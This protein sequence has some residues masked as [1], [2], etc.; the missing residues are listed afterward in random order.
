[1]IVVKLMILISTLDNLWVLTLWPM[2]PMLHC[3]AVG[4]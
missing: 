4:R 1:M 2:A 3:R